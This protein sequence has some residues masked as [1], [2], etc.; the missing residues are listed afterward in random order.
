MCLTSPIRVFPPPPVMQ[1][2]TTPPTLHPDLKS[3]LSTTFARRLYP[4]CVLHLEQDRLF[5]SS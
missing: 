2:L 4:E 3:N 5:M 1:R